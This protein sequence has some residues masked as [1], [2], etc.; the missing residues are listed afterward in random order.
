MLAEVTRILEKYKNIIHDIIV[1]KSSFEF[2]GFTWVGRNGNMVAHEI[3]ALC[4][5][6]ELRGNWIHHLHASLR[7]FIDLDAQ[8][9]VGMEMLD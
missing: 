7:R 1:L 4:N 8:I 2:C 6:N 3:A 9:E 5:R